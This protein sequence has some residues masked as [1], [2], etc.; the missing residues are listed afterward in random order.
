MFKYIISLLLL[1][2]S[3][4]TPLAGCAARLALVVGNDRYQNVASLK[5]AGADAKAVAEAL[6]K[7]DFRVT[8]VTNRTLREMKDDFRRFRTALTAN[9]DAVIYFSGHGVQIGATNYL[10]PTDVRD[11]SA[12]QVRDDSIALHE[13]M[14]DLKVSSPRT[15]I[16]II[17]ACRDNP[18]ERKGRHI[19][20]RG[21]STLS[22]LSTGQFVVYSAGEGELALDRLSDSDSAKNG[23]FAR[24][25]VREMEV[26]G[27]TVQQLVRN[28]R[29]QVAQLAAAVH[30]EQVPSLYEQTL[31]DFYFYPLHAGI[32]VSPTTSSSLPS[33]IDFWTAVKDS[34]DPKALRNFLTR[35]PSSK[36]FDLV[37]ERLQHVT[38][39]ESFKG[40]LNADEVVGQRKVHFPS[41]AIADFSKNRKAEGGDIASVISEDMMRSGLFGRVSQIETLPSAYDVEIGSQLRGRGFAIAVIGSE[42][43]RPNGKLEAKYKLIDLKNNRVLSESGL[44]FD[45]RV[46]IDTAHTFSDDIYERLTQRKGNF[47][48]YIAYTMYLPSHIE[49]YRYQIRMTSFGPE[50][51]N[52][53]VAGPKPLESPFFMGDRHVG[54][55][56]REFE[57]EGPAVFVQELKT[58]LRKLLVKG[59]LAGPIALSAD[60]K[61]IAVSMMIDHRLQLFQANS[62][63]TDLR[64]LRENGNNDSQPFFTSDGAFIYFV[65]DRMGKNM[66]FRMSLTTKKTDVVVANCE[67][68]LRPIISGDGQYLAFLS[69]HGRQYRLI[70]RDMFTLQ[71]KVLSVTDHKRGFA[72]A[73][74]SAVI[75]FVTEQHGDTKLTVAAPDGSMRFFI[76][77]SKSGIDYRDVAWED[78]AADGALKGTTQQQ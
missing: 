21:L 62:D 19:G 36:Y 74:N 32:G 42:I 54:Y 39:L 41:I 34:Q 15:T 59:E 55:I 51:E 6:R 47:R 56:S 57:P 11:D 43:V 28:V 9:D 66:I 73:P 71:E 35:F 67:E 44:A 16:A 8:L 49:K 27:I 2:V 23:V 37:K 31:I 50:Q 22:G 17:D 3:L 7:A 75:L 46:W 13:L 60:G 70:V 18:F 33:E 10:L 4:T 78:H 24:V 5:N 58:G 30:H 77:T 63:G 20:G 25:L 12:E 76:S 14:L 53:L 64:R 1:S 29:I 68:C 45:S 48:S 72:F 65:S 69:R 38:K 52:I 61:S 40:S 26:R